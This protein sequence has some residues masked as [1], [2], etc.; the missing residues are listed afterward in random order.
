MSLANMSLHRDDEDTQ[1]PLQPYI[2]TQGGNHS[3]SD[4]RSGHAWVLRRI[5]LIDEFHHG[6]LEEYIRL[7]TTPIV[8]NCYIHDQ[9]DL[10]PNN[11]CLT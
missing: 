3:I 1:L 5:G 9:K 4:S 6:I 2:Y 8:G 10:E 7:A 11:Q